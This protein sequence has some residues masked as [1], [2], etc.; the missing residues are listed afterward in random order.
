MPHAAPCI[1]L[2]RRVSCLTLD[3][4]ALLGLLK[5]M[6]EGRGWQG[7]ARRGLPDFCNSLNY[8]S[9]FKVYSQALNVPQTSMHEG[10][11]QPGPCTKKGHVEKPMLLPGIGTQAERWARESCLV[12]ITL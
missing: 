5:T 7:Q 3:F 10:P 6:E 9:A 11:A 12:I 1:S 4:F 8:Q 2:L